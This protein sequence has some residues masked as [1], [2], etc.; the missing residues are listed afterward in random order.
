MRCNIKRT[1]IRYGEEIRRGVLPVVLV[2]ICIGWMVLFVS[3]ARDMRSETIDSKEVKV[4]KDP[5]VNEE[6]QTPSRGE[7]R[8]VY[9]GEFKISFYCSCEICCGSGASG[10]MANGEEV[11][12]GAVGCDLDV[13]PM[14]TK[15]YI[16]DLGWYTV[17]DS[18]SGV[19]G[20]HI[21]IYVPSHE[22]AL[23]MGIMRKEV[24]VESVL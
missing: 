1:M 17:C 20:N 7:I 22:T 23:Q 11:Y 9:A 12:E 10:V 4:E 6:V 8:H 16:E 14:G 2:S 13:L 15:V 3:M 5:M 24:Y 21:D 19:I 18:G